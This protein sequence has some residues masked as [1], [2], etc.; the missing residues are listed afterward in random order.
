MARTKQKLI[1]FHSPNTS[2]TSVFAASAISYGEIAVRHNPAQPELYVR[3]GE[4]TYAVFVDLA[5]T[6]GL[7]DAAAGGINSGLAD[8]SAATQAFIGEVKDNYAKKSETGTAY[9]NATSYAASQANTAYS[10]ATAYT[11]TVSG[12]IKTAL[13]GYA[14]TGTTTAIDNRVTQL[15]GA[16]QE[17]S[18]GAV[19]YI[20][21]KLSNVYIYQGSV[22]VYENLSAFTGT[23]VV[24]DVY[25]VIAAHGTTPEGTNYAWNGTK[26]DALG[27]SVDLS[28]Y[29]LTATTTL[30]DNRV[31]QLSAATQGIETTANSA[32]QGYALGSVSTGDAH[33]STQ[34]G[35]KTSYTAG[36]TAKLDL[37]ELIIDCGNF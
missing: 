17:F 32:L 22:D 26:W 2:G 11:K 29:T 12:N 1:N 28:V 36:G 4:N 7:I 25:N 13:G 33:Y 23:A 24:G 19:S 6:Q 35:A 30:I 20:N 18:A 34:S 16:V 15:S 14:T 9:T 27:G 10:S 31:T 5:K 37:S 8:L 3:T 21:N